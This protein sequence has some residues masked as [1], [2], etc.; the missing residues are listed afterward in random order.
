MTGF[1]GEIRVTKLALGYSSS[2]FPGE[3]KRGVFG[4]SLAA[5]LLSGTA[6][7]QTTPAPADAPWRNPALPT[8]QR[9]NALIGQMTIEEKAS[10]LVNQA[11]AIRYFRYPCQSH[12]I[13]P[14]KVCPT[15]RWSTCTESFANT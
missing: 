6:L 11:R 15:T 2:T 8:E 3:A 14:G 4:L 12:S 9:V 1:W 5:L 10:Q 7:A 13:A